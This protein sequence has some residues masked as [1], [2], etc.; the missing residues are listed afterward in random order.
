LVGGKGQSWSSRGEFIAAAAEA[1]RRI[2][3]DNARRKK[4][5]KLEGKWERVSL[6]DVKVMNECVRSVDDL[7]SRDE[8]LD[9]VSQVDSEGS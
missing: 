9:D 3:V 5:L 4:S 6:D 1:M 2:L 8:A 7:L